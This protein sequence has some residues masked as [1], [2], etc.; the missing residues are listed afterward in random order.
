[1]IYAKLWAP[2]VEAV[3]NC[4]NPA[5]PTARLPPDPSFF[6]SPTRHVGGLVCSTTSALKKIVAAPN[7]YRWYCYRGLLEPRLAGEFLGQVPH[8][9][10]A[11]QRPGRAVPGQRRRAAGPGAVS[12]GRCR[13]TPGAWSSLTSRGRGAVGLGGS[14]DKDQD[15]EGRGK[16]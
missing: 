14:V 11:L 5:W 7:F 2:S 12:A 10:G 16:A 1:M 15:G 13:A 3:R 4:S 6:G 8:A 9:A